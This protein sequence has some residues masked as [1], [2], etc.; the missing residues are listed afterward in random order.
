MAGGRALAI[1]IYEQVNLTAAREFQH[2][3]EADAYS[4]AEHGIEEGQGH[5]CLSDTDG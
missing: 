4:A 5:S 2:R 3:R 1:K